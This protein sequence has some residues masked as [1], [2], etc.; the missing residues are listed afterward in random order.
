MVERVA[1]F[2]G[3]LDYHDHDSRRSTRGFPDLFLCRAPE[4]IVAE[5]KTDDGRVRPDQQ[6][7]LDALGEVERHLA[8]AL[9]VVGA[10]TTLDDPPPC[11]EVVVWRPAQWDEIQQRLARGRPFVPASFDPRL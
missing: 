11:F 9:E 7:W 2:Y 4:V 6:T 10:T 1:R 5:L 8:R 3:W